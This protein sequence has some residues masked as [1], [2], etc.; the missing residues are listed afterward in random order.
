MPKHPTPTHLIPLLIA[1]EQLADDHPNA[2]AIRAVLKLA[3]LRD[4]LFPTILET[5]TPAEL[6]AYINATLQDMSKILAIRLAMLK[7][8][9]GAVQAHYHDYHDTHA[10]KEQKD[11]A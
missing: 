10:P 1:I 7:D 5:H 3:T 2:D 4:E 8:S 9:L 11:H 6:D